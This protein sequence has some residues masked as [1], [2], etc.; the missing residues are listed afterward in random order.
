MREWGWG[1]GEGNLT[2]K[3]FP[4]S[5]TRANRLTRFADDFIIVFRVVTLLHAC[6]VSRNPLV[7]GWSSAD[8][9]EKSLPRGD[10]KHE[11]RGIML[12]FHCRTPERVALPRTGA[13]RR[14]RPL[15]V[16]PICLACTAQD[17]YPRFIRRLRPA[18]AMFA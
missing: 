13:R 4:F 17:L 6:A 7:R 1:G 5:R 2:G 16:P 9:R 8:E 15:C 11:Q 18:R 3:N 10:S 12:W 14:A